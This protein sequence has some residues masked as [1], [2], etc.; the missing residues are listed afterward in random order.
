MKEVQW[1]SFQKFGHY[2]IDWYINKKTNVNGKDEVQFTHVGNNDYVED[3]L[4]A[5]TNLAQYKTNVRCL[6]TSYCYH[7]TNNKY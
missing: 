2:A 1:Y 6:D 3:I 5:N 4:M 7:M